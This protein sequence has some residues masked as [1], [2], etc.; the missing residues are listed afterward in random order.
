METKD[1]KDLEQIHDVVAL[2]VVLCPQEEESDKNKPQLLLGATNT[3]NTDNNN[4]DN[5]SSNK[6]RGVW[7]CYHVLGL[8]N[9]F[10]GFNLYRRE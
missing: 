10:Q 9:I 7:L 1:L 8:V 2:R 4:N 5:E 3:A 6:G